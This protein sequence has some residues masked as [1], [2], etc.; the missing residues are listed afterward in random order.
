[1]R[2]LN[3]LSAVQIRNLKEAGYYAD[4][5]GLYLRVAPGGTKGWI[6]RASIHGRTR[7][8]GLGSVNA[9]SLAA[10]RAKA[11][12]CRAQLADGNDPI[13]HRK[14]QRV[15][16]RLDDAKARTFEECARA[17]IEAHEP[18]WR[19]AK[20]R[21]QWTN[22]LKTYVYPALG[23]LPAASIDTGLVLRVIEP[24]WNT[25]PETAGRVR[26]RIETVLDWAKVRGFRSGENPARWRGHLDHLLPARRKVRAVK[27]HAALPYTDVA[28]FMSALAVQEGMAALALRFTILTA[29]R[30]GEALNATWNEIEFTGKTWTIPAERMKAGREHRVPL[31]DAAMGVLESVHESAAD[32]QSYVFQGARPGRSLSQMALLMLLRRMHRGDITAH[33]FRSTFRDWAAECTSFS[34]EVAEMALAHAVSDAVEAA[35]R[36]GDLFEKRRKLMQAWA[37]YCLRPT[38][39]HNVIP[40]NRE[41]PALAG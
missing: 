29:A 32:G 2:A 23:K 33:G 15:Q 6:F 4:G 39:T 11:A 20:H 18:S 19:N 31:S 28:G 24:I 26:G 1:M 27:H 22:T 37:E 9:V 21:Q 5:G 10:A 16:A 12:E 41:L 7:D 8:M 30:T 38:D 25:K 36:R 14:A 17:Y 13:E 34:G 35:Y 3:R 40:I